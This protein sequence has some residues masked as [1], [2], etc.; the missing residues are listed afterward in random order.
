VRL[1]VD[2]QGAQ[3]SSRNRGIG[4]YCRSL[5]LAMAE[6]GRHD[7]RLVLNGGFGDATQELRDVFAGVLPR[8]SISVWYGPGRQTACRPSGPACSNRPAIATS[9]SMG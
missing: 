3:S 8:G 4:R 1:V 6:C 9:I 5:V 2:M 7:I